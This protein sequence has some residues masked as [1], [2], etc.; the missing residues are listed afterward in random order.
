M[1]KNRSILLH[2]QAASRKKRQRLFKEG[3]LDGAI[4]CE[5]CGQRFMFR[6]RYDYHMITKHTHEYPFQCEHCGHKTANAD[7]LRL[8]LEYV[9]NIGNDH[10]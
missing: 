3:K 1:R 2:L 10:I 5:V 9:H 6:Y 8:H 7:A 4:A